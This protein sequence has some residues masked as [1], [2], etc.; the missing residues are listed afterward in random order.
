MPSVLHDYAG[1]GNSTDHIIIRTQII[2]NKE[3]ILN[4]ARKKD[5]ITYKVRAFRVTPHFSVETLQARSVWTDGV[6]ILREHD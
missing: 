5:Q 1:L 4:E 3:R 2:Q 6:Q